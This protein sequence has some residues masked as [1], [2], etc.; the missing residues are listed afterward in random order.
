MSALAFA[1]IVNRPGKR[2]PK[3]A[4]YFLFIFGRPFVKRFALCYRTVVLSVCDVGVLW[5]NSWMNQDK[6]WRA[7]RP[8][9][10]P[11]CVTW[12]PPIFGPYAPCG[13]RGSK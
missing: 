8:R 5:P 7:G 9:P 2:R 13:L 11:Q 12:G 1:S 3:L 6:T 10:W 4:L